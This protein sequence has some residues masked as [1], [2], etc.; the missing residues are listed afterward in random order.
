MKTKKR[1]F[2][3]SLLP[4]AAKIARTG[5]LLACIA[6]GQKV[7]AQQTIMVKQTTMEIGKATVGKDME[8]NGRHLAPAYNSNP[9]FDKVLYFTITMLG[10]KTD[11][12]FGT[13]GELELRITDELGNE[14]TE[15]DRVVL[16]KEN[17]HTCLFNVSGKARKFKLHFGKIK[18]ID[19]VVDNLPAEQPSVT[20]KS[21][22]ER[23][24]DMGDYKIE[25]L[26]ATTTSEKL[27][28]VTGGRFVDGELEWDTK[29]YD[30]SELPDSGVAFGIIKY[31]IVNR[32]KR[33]MEFK[34]DSMSVKIDGKER[35][36]RNEWVFNPSEICFGEGISFKIKPGMEHSGYLIFTSPKELLNR[37][38]ALQWP[39][40]EKIL[41]LT[42]SQFSQAS[43]VRKREQVPNSRS[44][45]EEKEDREAET[46]IEPEPQEQWQLEEAS[47]FRTAPQEEVRS[48]SAHSSSSQLQHPSRQR[49]SHYGESGAGL[50][51]RGFIG[52]N[53]GVAVPLGQALKNSSDGGAEAYFGF[54]YL[55]S[56]HI[57]MTAMLFSTS[58]ML[59]N[60]D[61]ASVGLSGMLAGPL[62]SAGG[63]T[64][65][66][67]WDFK[68]MIGFARGNVSIGSDSGNTKEGTFVIGAGSTLRWNTGERW[69]IS[70]GANYING[71]INNVDLSSIGITIG[72]NYRF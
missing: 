70:F 60:Y 22:K 55:F 15:D 54:G 8:V 25:I 64:G 46:Q 3:A 19:L 31:R 41:K 4:I 71:K 42:F 48:Q 21:K 35:K 33:E 51:R 38:T 5:F 39:G 10:G 49:S 9:S 26:D 43:I 28:F 44:T 14:T 30:P 37:I 50:F 24:I 17:V 18:T 34:I 32:S 20:V 13:G 7:F 29:K 16:T 53:V 36:L 68:P 45:P 63:S 67:E 1:H 47:Q 11:F 58:F 12:A 27:S 56:E 40:S 61:D 59:N 6:F 2:D 66:I 65:K 23:T 57:G 52:L 72:A 69:S 62:F